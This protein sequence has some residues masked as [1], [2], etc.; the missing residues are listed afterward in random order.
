[1]NVPDAASRA[2]A[3]A[4]GHAPA[5]LAGFGAGLVLLQPLGGEMRGVL[6]HVVGVSFRACVRVMKMVIMMVLLITLLNTLVI[7]C[8]RLY[9]VYRSLSW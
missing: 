6:A 2:R 7:L 1:M 4:L 8:L 9:T 3:G 5:V